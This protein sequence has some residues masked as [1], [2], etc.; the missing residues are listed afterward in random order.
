M[1]LAN[2]TPEAIST[3]F[4]GVTKVIKS[5]EIVEVGVSM[6]NHVLNNFQKR[7][8]IQLNYGDDK[9]IEQRRKESLGLFTKFWERQIVVF[10]QHNER[11]KNENKAYIMPTDELEAHATMLGLELVGPWKLKLPASTKEVESLRVENSDLRDT[12]KGLGDQ[13]KNLTDAMNAY[14]IKD[15]N[16]KTTER[17]KYINQF[18]NK[19]KPAFKAWVNINETM[20]RA[21]PAEIQEE[22]RAKWNG[23]YDEPWPINND[24]SKENQK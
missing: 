10:N 21:W 9:I 6:G 16:L 13:V 8:L 7:G 12:V 15:S 24:P 20:I 5:M 14:F 11:L 3:Q 18:R 17:D 22:A 2:F 1:I 19:G 23:Y 4:A